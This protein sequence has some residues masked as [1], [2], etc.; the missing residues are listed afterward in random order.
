[1]PRKPRFAYRDTN[2]NASAGA[3]KPSGQDHQDFEPMP[4]EDGISLLK[5]VMPDAEPPLP[6]EGNH[7]AASIRALCQVK[8]DEK[9]VL[10]DFLCPIYGKTAEELEAAAEE[11]RK[12]EEAKDLDNRI[13]NANQ[14]TTPSEIEEICAKLARFSDPITREKRIKALSKNTGLSVS[15]IKEK[16]KQKEEEYRKGY[17][18]GKDGGDLKKIIRRLLPNFPGPAEAVLPPGYEIDEMSDCVLQIHKEGF[19]TAALRPIIPIQRIVDISN[20][21]VQ[22]TCAIYHDGKWSTITDDRDTFFDKSKIIRLATKDVPVDSTTAGST[23]RFIAETEIVNR[24]VIPETKA[25]KTFGW[26]KVRDQLLFA[27]PNCVLTPN[28]QTN[29]ILVLPADYGEEQFFSAFDV[30][31]S[32]EEWVDLYNRVITVTP[33][34]LL[35]VSAALASTL[36]PRLGISGGLLHLCGPTSRGKTTAMQFAASAIGYPGAAGQSADRGLIVDWFGTTVSRERIFGLFRH[37][38][39]F[40]DENRGLRPEEVTQAAYMLANGTGKSRGSTRGLQKIAR[41]QIFAVSTGERTMAELSSAGGVPVRAIDLW[42][43]P[44]IAFPDNSLVTEA[45]EVSL[46]CYGHA[47]RKF[48]QH[49]MANWPDNKL[50]DLYKTLLSGILERVMPKAEDAAREM[51]GRLSSLWAAMATAYW[52]LEEVVDNPE[53]I[54]GVIKMFSHYFLQTLGGDA[55]RHT[56]TRAYEDLISEI[57]S[58]P[59]DMMGHPSADKQPLTGWFG[60]WEVETTNEF[61][62]KVRCFAVFPTKFREFCTRNGYPDKAVL[63]AWKENGILLAQGTHFARVVRLDSGLSK[64]YVIRKPEDDD[65]EQ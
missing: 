4:A 3:P 41:W 2:D 10:L 29:D 38:P 27:L 24:P 64:M 55:A 57:M 1:L 61:G 28:G 9:Q 18:E 49:V 25:V 42:C 26:H 63:M 5:R 7:W 8:Q 17:K 59:K 60:K 23:V 53:E 34:A 52:I 47:I 12:A 46:R 39:V 33:A 16:I 56:H 40:I 65:G 35:A 21:E 19:T 22:L 11:F 13:A 62:E 43:D 31:G 37:L 51:I 15:S 20:N 32:W 50:A 6:T 30:A 36:L 48:I 44:E 14:D 54:S 45:R 58:R